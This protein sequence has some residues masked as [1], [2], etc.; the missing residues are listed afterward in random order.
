MKINKTT[1]GLTVVIG[2]AI[3]IALYVLMCILGGFPIPRG[4][5]VNNN[6]YTY[7]KN[8]FGIYYISVENAPALFNH[9]SWGYLED[10]DNQTFKV[11][12]EGWAKDNN[13][14][15][16]RDQPVKNVDVRS[17]HIN[18]HGVAIDKNRVYLHDFLTTTGN[19]FIRPSHSGI[20]V[21]TAEYFIYR[22]GD[23]QDEWM[24]DKDFVYH[25]DKRINVDRNSFEIY[26][27]DW[28]IDK[29]FLYKTLYNNV[30]KKWDLHRIDSLQKPIEA[31]YHYFRNGR[32]IIYYD[33]IILKDIDVQRFEEIGV[34]KYRINNMLFLFG[35]PFLKDSLNVENARFYF[36]GHIAA[37]NENVYYTHKLLDDIDA[38]TF[39]QID[40]ETFEDKSYI[41]TI[42]KN[43][44]RET[45]PFVKKK[46]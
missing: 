20:D 3:I 27:E 7:Y 28:F 4:N 17:F 12:G 1:I 34:G 21:E 43:A 5:K 35:K 40:D 31:G 32:N 36:Y 13:H 14:V 30:T 25:Y 33:S 29:D 2:I 44:W 39:R 22:L 45:Y 37:D 42:K 46:K 18:E 26:G 38:S 41:Y 19:T 23:L 10:V 9:G 15:W 8:I 16:R 24:R 6:Y 11:L